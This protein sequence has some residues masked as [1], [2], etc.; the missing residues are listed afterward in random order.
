MISPADLVAIVEKASSLAD[1]MGSE[2]IPVDPTPDLEQ[3]DP[4]IQSV[5]DKWGMMSAQGDEARFQSGWLGM[6]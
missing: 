4:G 1:R 6:D 2:F 3:L 5:L